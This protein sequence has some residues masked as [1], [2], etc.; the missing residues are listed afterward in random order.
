MFHSEKEEIA[1]TYTAKNNVAQTEYSDRF[2]TL[3]AVYGP[4]V[5]LIMIDCN[6]DS[7]QT[8]H[9]TDGRKRKSKM[10]NLDTC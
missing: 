9:G 6:N 5:Q 4:S 1:D 3:T 7:Y 8:W 2:P 10:I